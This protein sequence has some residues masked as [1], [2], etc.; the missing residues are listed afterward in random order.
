MLLGAL[1]V[2]DVPIY[3]KV[4]LV[5]METP[6]DGDERDDFI[7]NHYNNQNILKLYLEKNNQ[8]YV[9][10]F[11]LNETLDITPINYMPDEIFPIEHWWIS[12][13]SP[14][15][16]DLGLHKHKVQNSY[17]NVVS[18]TKRYVYRETNY[19]Y[20]IK[21]RGEISTPNLSESKTNGRFILSIEDQE[22][23]YKGSLESKRP[24]L[25]VANS[26]TVINVDSNNHDKFLKMEWMTD[27]SYGSNFIIE[28]G[29]G[30]GPFNFIYNSTENTK[31]GHKY[32][33][34][35]SSHTIKAIKVNNKSPIKSILDSH[36]VTYEIKQDRYYSG[37]HY[38]TAKINYSLFFVNHHGIFSQGDMVLRGGYN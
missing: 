18:T 29:Y 31:S 15:E 34:E 25:G 13:F 26:N 6:L 19:E 3:Q 8:F 17:N 30:I 14:I 37:T 4:I 5:V 11:N 10:E 33:P 7:M 35:T 20:R 1:E 38:I 32:I 12:V 27:S 24:I 22:T 2:L 9:F 36:V 16:E 23:Y 28:L 21:L